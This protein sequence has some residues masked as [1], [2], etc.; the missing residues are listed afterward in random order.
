MKIYNISKSWDHR[1]C[2]LKKIGNTPLRCLSA[3]DVHGKGQLTHLNY[4]KAAVKNLKDHP[5]LLSR[6]KSEK[7][8]GADLFQNNLG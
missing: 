8:A 5:F 4:V 3:G 6:R 7:E 1:L 2:R